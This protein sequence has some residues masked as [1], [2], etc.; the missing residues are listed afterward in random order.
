MSRTLNSCFEFAAY[1]AGVKPK[2][3]M[4][5]PLV[6]VQL[7]QEFD[8]CDFG[9][10]FKYRSTRI[11]M[12]YFEYSFTL[13]PWTMQSSISLPRHLKASK[14]NRRHLTVDL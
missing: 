12:F 7:K 6:A 9:F 14:G 4:S 11:E 10:I 8:L 13:H 1:C 5:R 3:K 2:L